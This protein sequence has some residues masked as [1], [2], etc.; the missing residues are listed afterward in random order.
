MGGSGGG[1]RYSLFVG[2][3]VDGL[4]NGWLEKILA[5]RALALCL[6]YSLL[7]TL[8]ESAEG[9]PLRLVWLAQVAGPVTSFRRPSPPFAFVEYGE[10]ESVL[11]CL[12]VVNAAK[13]KMPSGAE[14][15]LLVKA[16]EKTRGRLDEYEKERVQNQVRIQPPRSS[17]RL[18]PAFDAS[19]R[20]L[21]WGC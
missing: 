7:V 4:E 2:S 20:T 3:I 11:R 19:S 18:K 21:T 15:E 1:E 14:K 8:L 9:Y 13:I 5:V 10:P 12:E 16:D 17:S 6:I